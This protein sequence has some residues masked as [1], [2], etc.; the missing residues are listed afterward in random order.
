MPPRPVGPDWIRR[1]LSFAIFLAFFVRGRDA[2]FFAPLAV[3]AIDTNVK[4]QMFLAAL[5]AYMVIWPVTTVWVAFMFTGAAMSLVADRIWRR[6]E[7]DREQI[8]E[9]NA[10]REQPILERL[11]HLP[12][13]D[14]ADYDPWNDAW[15]DDGYDVD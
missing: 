8:Q 1:R 12:V 4:L 2:A 5:F 9:R 10:A 7:R 14:W 6:R 13:D 15:P 3:L 11:W